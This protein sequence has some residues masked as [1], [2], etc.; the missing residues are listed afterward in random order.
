MEFCSEQIEVLHWKNVSFHFEFEVEMAFEYSYDVRFHS[1]RR[2][3]NP[4][5]GVL[6]R[7]QPWFPI[8]KSRESISFR[9]PS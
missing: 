8:T 2:A 3:N 1:F 9:Q 6:M 4:S 5:N 7:D